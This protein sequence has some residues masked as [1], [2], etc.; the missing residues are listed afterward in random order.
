MDSKASLGA[1]AASVL[2]KACLSIF[3][4]GV[5]QKHGQFC[6]LG[7]AFRG[8]TVITEQKQATA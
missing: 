8:N 5:E 1:K 3:L 2:T 4:F 6:V 7:C